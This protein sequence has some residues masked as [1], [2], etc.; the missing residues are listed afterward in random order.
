MSSPIP[1]VVVSFLSG[2]LHNSG[3]VV[4]TAQSLQPRPVPHAP[5]RRWRDG[6]GGFGGTLCR[7]GLCICIPGPSPVPFVQ[8]LP[9]SWGAQCWFRPEGIWTLFWD[10]GFPQCGLV[11]KSPLEAIASHTLGECR[12]S[13]CVLLCRAFG[14]FFLRSHHLVEKWIAEVPTKSRDR[15]KLIGVSY[16]C[17]KRIKFSFYDYF[18]ELVF[19]ICIISSMRPFRFEN[20]PF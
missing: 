13:F 7:P 18:G 8:H 2:C 19:D 11:Q 4:R 6:R 1:F 10:T 16:T 3:P 5:T 12:H 17:L 14:V 15:L 9:T 20:E